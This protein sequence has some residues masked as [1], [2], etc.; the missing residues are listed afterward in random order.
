MTTQTVSTATVASSTPGVK[1]G[2]L[3]TEFWLNNI[4]QVVLF[5]NTAGVWKYVHPQWATLI[6]QGG[7]LGLYTISR[8]WV[9]GAASK[10]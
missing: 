4:A 5:L 6:V 1:P 8:A 3:T 2:V 7:V 9:K 10:G